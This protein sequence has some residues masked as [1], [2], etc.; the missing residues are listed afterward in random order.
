MEAHSIFQ[1]VWRSRCTPRIKFFAWLV[2][3]DR[4]NTKPMLQRRHLDV[5]DDDICVMCSSGQPKTIEHLFFECPFA[6]ECWAI[7]NFQWDLSL[8]LH[9]RLVA[10][11]QNHNLPFCTEAALIA[12]WEIWKMRNDKVFQRRNPTPALWLSNFKN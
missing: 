4:L 2:V 10:A 5:H 12:A 9:D 3:V 7:V 8:P 1:V 11:G 6:A